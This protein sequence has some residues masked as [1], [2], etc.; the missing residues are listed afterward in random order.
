MARSDLLK[1]LFAAHTRA[2]DTG[3][4][5]IAA[6]LIADERRLGHRLLAADLEHALHRDATISMTDAPLTLR[7]LPRGRD[8][9]PLLAVS[10]PRHELVDLVLSDDCRTA[11]SE[12]VEENRSRSLLAGFRLVPRRRLLFIGAS[13]TGK[14]AS[15]HAIAAELSLPVATVSLAALTS[16]FLG[17]TAK[18]IEAVLNFA[19]L[20]PCVLVFD[21]FDAVAADR[22]T[23]NDH[24]E[25][26][27][28]MATMLQLV[29]N[30]QGESVVVATS[31]HPDLLDAAMWRR[32][33]DVVAFEPLAVAGIEALLRLRLQGVPHRLSL[34]SWSKRLDGMTPAEIELVALDAQRRW[35]L[36]GRRIL[37]AEHLTAALHRRAAARRHPQRDPAPN[38]S[39]P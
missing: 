7:A 18:N 28:V 19:E 35:V 27:R 31:N 14:T 17:D 38:A 23:P 39:L 16:S 13:G 32:F 20:T 37:G 34:R 12:I 3:F 21:E 4:R 25:M 15:A 33:D 5:D 29:E 22:S 8:E 30:V 2:D 10:K 1:Q 26:R 36:S 24:G 6:R 11:V 9:R